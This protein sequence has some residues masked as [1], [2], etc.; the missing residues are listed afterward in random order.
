MRDY[1][2]AALPYPA[3]VVIGLIVYRRMKATL[4]GQG[5][6][7]NTVDEIRSFREEIWI[8]INALLAEAKAKSN[9]KSKK[10]FWILGGDD[11]SEA[12]A[13]LFGFIE[14]VLA[15]TA[16]VSSHR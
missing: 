13:T 5:T 1:I 4:D 6:G 10:P 8:N 2:L 3:R 15:Y 9:D 12:D 11:P 7:R 16:D 14:S